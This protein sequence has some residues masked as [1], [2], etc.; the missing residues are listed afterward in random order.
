[1]RTWPQDGDALSRS[2][3]AP[4]QWPALRGCIPCFRA[5]RPCRTVRHIGM[6]RYARKPAPET[7]TERVTPSPFAW[8]FRR[9][10][11]WTFATHRAWYP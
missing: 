8:L 2:W 5:C 3:L 9:P 11:L 4:A 1:M 7:V 6:A 10:Y